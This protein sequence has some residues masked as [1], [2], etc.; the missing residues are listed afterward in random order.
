MS[1]FVEGVG[2][3]PV[4]VGNRHAGVAESHVAGP[5]TIQ[6]ALINNMPDAALEDTETQ[7]F[8]LLD[9][10][11]QGL[12]V[13]LKLV[14]LPNVPRDQLGAQ[15]LKDVYFGVEELWNNSCDAI[16]VTGTEPQQADLRQE[17]YWGAMA[18]LLEW[19]ERNTLSTIL[20]CLAAHAS[21][22]HGDGIGRV[23]LPDKAF[24]VFDFT[25]SS[26]HALIRRSPEVL[27]FPHSR[28]NGLSAEALAVSGYQILTRNAKAGVDCFVKRKGRSLF[29]HFQGHPEYQAHTLFKEY[30]RD[31]RRFLRGDREAYPTMP[32]G[33]FSA[34][35]EKSLKEFQKWAVT[36]RSEVVMAAFPEAL[37]TSQLQNGWYAPAVRVYRNWLELLAEKKAEQS[38]C[39]PVRASR[40]ANTF[41]CRE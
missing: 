25:K 13:H 37:A 16:I 23:R 40:D 8:E 18:R 33:Y 36:N 27:R 20:S 35:A 34:D 38:C 32:C 2:G 31:V 9:A 28:W 5:E 1:V 22:L 29:V 7:F 24:G 41:R 3:R 14:S 17:P 26:E 19:A 4:W 39:V 12:S 30:R 11:T 15:R 6:L 10:A 21:V